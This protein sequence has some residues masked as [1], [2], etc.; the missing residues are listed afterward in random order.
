MEQTIFASAAATVTPGN[1][2]LN[3]EDIQWQIPA[4]CTPGHPL[5]LIKNCLEDRSDLDPYDQIDRQFNIHME[6]LKKRFSELAR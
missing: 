5:E 6:C 4:A 1:T 3:W 2:S